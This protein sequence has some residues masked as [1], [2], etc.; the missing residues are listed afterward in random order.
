MGRMSH[1][2]T[3]LYHEHTK[4]VFP[5]SC[6]AHVWLIRESGEVGSALKK[7]HHHQ[8][9][10]GPCKDLDRLTLEVP[11]VIYKLKFVLEVYRHMWC[12]LTSMRNCCQLQGLYHLH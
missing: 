2:Q 11:K 8:W 1:T 7:F 10:Y 12:V 3:S 6:Q 9:L 4:R 5:S